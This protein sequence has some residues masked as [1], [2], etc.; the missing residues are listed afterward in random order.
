MGS[1][2]FAQEGKSL[3]HLPQSDSVSVSSI[4]FERILNTFLWNGRVLYAGDVGGMRIATQQS[5]RSRLIRDVSTQDEYRGNLSVYAHVGGRW[6][7]AGEMFSSVLSDNAAIDFGRLAQHHFLVGPA[8]GH[9]SLLSVRLLG[10]YKFLAQGGERDAGFSYLAEL[11]GKEWGGEELRASV[12]AHSSQSFVTPR[13]WRDDSVAVAID[14]PFGDVAHA[15]MS[16]RYSNQR[17]EFYTAADSI[18]Q[19]RYAIASNIFKREAEGFEINSRW[20]Y[21]PS[22]DVSVLVE[23]GLENRT[24]DRGLRYKDV[25]SFSGAA[26]DTRVQQFQLVGSVSVSYRPVSWLR[27]GLQAY[28]S[29]REERHTVD[30]AEGVLDVVFLRQVASAKRL[31]NIARRTTLATEWKADLSQRN[32]LNLMGSASILRYDTPDT[33]NTDDRDE[34]RL[35]LG[36]EE[37]YRVSPYVRVSLLAEV[38]LTHLVY[39]HRSQS[40][41]NN[42]N[43]VFRLS[44]RVEYTPSTAIRSV[45]IAEVLANYTVY[46]FEEQIALVRSFSFR[47]ASWI[48]ST[49]IRLSQRVGVDIVGSVRVS[50]RGILRWREFTERPENAFVDVS[51]WPRL[52]LMVWDDLHVGIGFRYFHQDRYAVRAGV[53]TFERRL[54]SSGPTVQVRWKQVLTL[55]GWREHQSDDGQARR[56]IS[57]ISMNIS[58][59]F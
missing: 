23:G 46:D 57:N 33:L 39:L 35:T 58:Y 26:L 30:E 1:P 20:V 48:D 22:Q 17:R 13:R 41:N 28:Y 25:R 43:R 37:V 12:L 36:V 59:G 15:S 5:V 18:L 31:A 34:L 55:E 21:R 50:L 6:N 52:K 54:S 4:G 44:P 14:R 10:G 16:V 51:L 7:V 11:A 3:I 32:Q 8:Y 47:Q 42:W 38:G 2:A 9:A 24:I 19:R 40:A 29:E 27:G 49:F 56:S 45:N 53:R